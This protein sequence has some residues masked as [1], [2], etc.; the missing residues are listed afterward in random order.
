MEEQSLT[1]LQRK[2]ARRQKAK[3]D[4]YYLYDEKDDRKAEEDDVDDIP[5]VRLDDDDL[6]LGGKSESARGAVYLVRWNMLRL[7]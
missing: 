6:Q 2:A 4:P 7:R 3:D 1:D 5:I